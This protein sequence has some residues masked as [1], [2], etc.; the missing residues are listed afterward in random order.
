M[1]KEDEPFLARW[2]R[3]KRAGGDPDPS[4]PAAVDVAK[5]AGG[6][7]ADAP[8]PELPPI[9]QLTPESD[10]RPFMDPRVPD[11]LR[12]VALKKLYADPQFNVQD[13]L[14]DFAEDYTLLETLPAGMAG[15]LA[16]ARR[17]LLGR[18]EADRID[19]EERAAE[20]KTAAGDASRPQEGAVDNAAASPQVVQVPEAPDEAPQPQQ[21]RASEK[22]IG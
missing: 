22:D 16:H 19:A 1:T 5:S 15:K 18:E 13:M 17:T 8:L 11:A 2:S 4:A 14:D 6:S 12:R 7:T 3:L 10:F 21:S 9:D 20:A